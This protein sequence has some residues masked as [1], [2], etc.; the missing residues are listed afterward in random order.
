MGSR[1]SVGSWAPGAVWAHGRRRLKW[2]TTRVGSW[3]A[4]TLC[5]RRGVR[6]HGAAGARGVGVGGRGSAERRERMG[7]GERRRRDRGRRGGAETVAAWLRETAASSPAQLQAR[8]AQLTR[9]VAPWLCHTEM[10]RKKYGGWEE[11]PAMSAHGAACHCA[12]ARSLRTHVCMAG[13]AWQVVHTHAGQADS[14][15]RSLSLRPPRR[16]PAR[17]HAARSIEQDWGRKE[18]KGGG[19]RGLLLCGCAKGE[20]QTRR[21]LPPTVLRST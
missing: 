7:G 14:S 11:R 18:V 9:R 5:G 2:A 15:L 8:E 21:N 13:G 19:E 3:A 4:R 20:T 10:R 16:P 17:W 12:A 6:A 1:G